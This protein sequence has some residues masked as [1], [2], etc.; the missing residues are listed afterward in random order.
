MSH[1]E[2][3]CCCLFQLVIISLMSFVSMLWLGQYA[4]I[5]FASNCS[6]TKI[7]AK[8]VSVHVDIS[9]QICVDISK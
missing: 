8:L 4:N 5:S 6:Y 3:Y 2:K 7:Q 1:K 9:T